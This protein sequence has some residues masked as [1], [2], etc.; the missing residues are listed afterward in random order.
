MLVSPV[1]YPFQL[2]D[3]ALIMAEN[4]KHS[5]PDGIKGNVISRIVTPSHSCGAL[6]LKD[7]HLSLHEGEGEGY[8]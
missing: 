6:G 1:L 5:R 3:I 4:P 7:D 8:I 2:L